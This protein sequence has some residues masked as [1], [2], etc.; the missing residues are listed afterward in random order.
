MLGERTAE[1]LRL[2]RE[3]EE[4]EFFGSVAELEKKCRYYLKHGQERDKVA[5]AGLSRCVESG[6]SNED[7]LHSLLARLRRDLM[8]PSPPTEARLKG[9]PE[10]D[11]Q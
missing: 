2:F 1:H 3:G 11:R 6:Y 8:G 9:P 7:R 5:R 4:A 10:L